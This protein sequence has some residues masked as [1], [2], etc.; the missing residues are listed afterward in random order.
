MDNETEHNNKVLTLDGIL[1]YGFYCEHCER[2]NVLHTLSGADTFKCKSCGGKSGMKLPVGGYDAFGNQWMGQSGF[3][4]NRSLGMSGFSGFNPFDGGAGGTGGST[5]VIIQGGGGGGSGRVIIRG[6]AGGGIA[7]SNGVAM[8]GGS[9]SRFGQGASNTNF[10]DGGMVTPPVIDRFNIS[11]FNTSSEAMPVT[12]FGAKERRT[13]TNFGLPASIII[14]KENNPL[15]EQTLD[16]SSQQPFVISAF[17]I[18]SSRPEQL[19][20]M[21]TISTMREGIRR[22]TGYT[23]KESITPFSFREDSNSTSG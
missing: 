22:F 21:I 6:G 18:S 16:Q 10:R 14:S 13:Q 8:G 15:Y 11:L 19:E 12:L 2:H 5:N 20:R 7:T 17:R 23:P 9:G 3:S 1:S 4:G